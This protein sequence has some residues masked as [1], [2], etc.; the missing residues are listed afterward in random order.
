MAQQNDT[1]TQ[2]DFIRQ[3]LSTLHLDLTLAASD[4]F[5]CAAALVMLVEVYGIVTFFHVVCSYLCAHLSVSF[6]GEILWRVKCMCCR[7]PVLVFTH[8]A[9]KAD[10]NPQKKLYLC[11]IDLLNILLIT[12]CYISSINAKTKK[13]TFMS[14]L[15][16]IQCCPVFH[17]LQFY[18]KH[19]SLPVQVIYANYRAPPSILWQGAV[20]L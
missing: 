15:P 20:N 2:Q 16:E 6:S 4:V 3:N 8:W 19:S 14:F 5:A 10:V 17:L 7:I 13:R 11:P 18:L 9:I 12:Y 1:E